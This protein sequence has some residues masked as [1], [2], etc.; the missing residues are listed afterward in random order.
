MVIVR[1]FIVKNRSF[2]SAPRDYLRT[3]PKIIPARV[4]EYFRGAQHDTLRTAIRLS[5]DR[6]QAETS[7]AKKEKTLYDQR[8]NT[9]GGISEDGFSLGDTGQPHR[10]FNYNLFCTMEPV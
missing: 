4:A 8:R 1:D 3:S 9:H 2:S 5:Q 7:V 6:N 10:S